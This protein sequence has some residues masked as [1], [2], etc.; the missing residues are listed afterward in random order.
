M[1]K[2]TLLMCLYTGAA[3]G[4][5][6][7]IGDSV[8]SQLLPHA[9]ENL[10]IVILTNSGIDRYLA[11]HPANEFVSIEYIDQHLPRGFLQKLFHF[12]YAYLIF[13]GT[14]EVLATIGARADIT[15]AGGNQYLVFL[16]QG[17]ART[18]GRS[19]W[20]K[21]TLVPWLYDRVFRARPYRKIF[22]HYAPSLVFVSALAFYP[23]I[24]VVAEAKR[25]SIPTLGM[26]PNWDH[27]N[28]Y[29][30]PQ[31]VDT[32][33]VQN[34][35]MK[36]E[37]ITLH[38]Y[39][40][41]QVAL[42]GFLQFDKYVPHDKYVLPR[43]EYFKEMGLDTN[44]KV[45][46]YFSNS[47]FTM[48]EGDILQEI[49]H[50]IRDG[51]WTHDVQLLV[52]P[53]V[54]PRSMALEEKKYEKLQGNPDIRFNWRKID[55]QEESSRFFISMMYYADVVISLFSTTA[56]EAAV[57][58]KPTLTVGFD[59]YK[60]YPPHLSITRLEKLT[61]F[62]N[63]ID[64]GGVPIM[65]SFKELHDK[66]EAYLDNPQ[67]DKDKRALLVEKLCYAPDGRTAGRLTG[68]ILSKLRGE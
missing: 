36:L 63:V 6:I 50:W 18:F 40:D 46:A 68:I 19:R 10:R 34:M 23:D 22:D 54:S 60:Q 21:I 37:A 49:A 38:A 29:Y 5:F 9:N 62:K 26:T 41:E 12:F 4:K 39:R 30:I 61:Y 45:I 11:K 31:H 56:L 57:F 52:R 24:E 47:A 15:P 55:E 58:D 66:V 20:V 14:T 33:L 51:A 8:L 28:K 7:E 42:L 13:T 32:L 17:I 53:Y 1:E 44:R 65:R 67:L 27:L 3:L 48:N 35:P 25:R 59:G 2:K 43:D 16:K 64:T